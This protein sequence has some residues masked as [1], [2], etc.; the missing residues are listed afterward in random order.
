MP[1]FYAVSFEHDTQPV[2]T[3]RGEVEA[4][5]AGEAVKRAVFRAEKA[6]VGKWKFRSL[7]VVVEELSGRGTKDANK[8][9][10]SA[11]DGSRERAEP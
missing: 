7:V 1:F 11:G 6:R 5:D 10:V 2:E 8:T 9:G 4:T 3:I